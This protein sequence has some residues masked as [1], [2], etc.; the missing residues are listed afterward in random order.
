MVDHA[1]LVVS[2]KFLAQA[3]GRGLIRLRHAQ[4][5]HRRGPGLAGHRLVLRPPQVRRELLRAGKA[6][7]IAL[8]DALSAGTCPVVEVHISNI[9]RRE[10]FR[11]HSYVSK[12]ATAVMAGFGTHGYVLALRHVAHLLG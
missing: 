12:A 6:K 9:H 5:V 4:P 8:L 10:A 1:G 7:G 11:E 3:P 2:F